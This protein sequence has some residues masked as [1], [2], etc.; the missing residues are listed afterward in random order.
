MMFHSWTFGP[1]SSTVNQALKEKE[2]H[3]L[4]L[5][6]AAGFLPAYGLVFWFPWK[7]GDIVLRPKPCGKSPQEAL[8]SLC[9]PPQVQRYQ[10]TLSLQL[11]VM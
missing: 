1:V 2:G 4:P 6:P 5:V 7:V 10:K 8:S 11:P 3:E 9:P